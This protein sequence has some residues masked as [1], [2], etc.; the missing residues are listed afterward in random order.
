M[1]NLLLHNL[2]LWSVLMRQQWGWTKMVRS[3]LLRFWWQIGCREYERKGIRGESDI[4]GMN[5][6][7]KVEK[8]CRCVWGSQLGGILMNFMSDSLSLNCM[9]E[10]QVEMFKSKL[11]KCPMLRTRIWAK[12]TNLGGTALR[13][14]VH[15]KGRK[16]WRRCHFPGPQ[17]DRKI[18]MKTP[19]CSGNPSLA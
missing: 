8:E 4:S 11:D 10:F 5:N 13:P 14:F 17:R 12:D 3:G 1:G 9:R 15:W 19:Q 7:V 18:H 16:G 2:Y 6:W